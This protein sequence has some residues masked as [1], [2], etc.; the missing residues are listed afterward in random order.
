LKSLEVLATLSNDFLKNFKHKT[1]ENYGTYQSSINFNGMPKKHFLYQ[2]VFGGCLQRYSL[3][4][5]SPNPYSRKKK[6]NYAY[7]FAFGKSVP[8]K[9][10]GNYGSQTNMRTEVKL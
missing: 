10:S 6:I 1:I 9:C 5:L 3:Q 7:R 4:R 2:S 8:F